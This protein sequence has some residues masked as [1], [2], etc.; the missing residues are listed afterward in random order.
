MIRFGIPSEFV[1]MV[2]SIYSCRR[3][4]VADG[5][6]QSELHNQYFGISQGCPLSPFLFVILMTILMMDADTQLQEKHGD[7][8]SGDL[9]IHS[10][11]YADDTLLID[12]SDANLEIYMN[13]IAGLGK[14]YGLVLN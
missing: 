10:L 6:Y 7:I 12:S 5:G 14:I 9:L 13:I 11:L 3:F 2:D 1:A 8:F 4:L